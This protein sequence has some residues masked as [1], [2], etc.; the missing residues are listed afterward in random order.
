MS[1]PKK[2]NLSALC[3]D[4]TFGSR[5]A[6]SKPILANI[7]SQQHAVIRRDN[8]VVRLSAERMQKGWVNAGKSVLCSVMTGKGNSGAQP[9]TGLDFSIY[10]VPNTHPAI[11]SGRSPS[12]RSPGHLVNLYAKRIGPM[13]T[14][15]L[16][17][18]YKIGHRPKFGD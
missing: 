8:G 7:T 14:S 3:F 2:V 5:L 18:G 9:I 10:I 12:P 6:I 4:G 11:A 15:G 13:I 17:Y 1:D 16:A